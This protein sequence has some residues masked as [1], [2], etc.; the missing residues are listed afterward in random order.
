MDAFFASVEVLD[1]PS[2]QGKPVVVG[3]DANRGVVAAASYEARKFGI[4]SAL[5]MAIAIRRCPH[6]IFLPPRISRYR[7]IS[8]EIF[9]IFQS[10]T[11]LV[12][13]ISL[14]EAFLDVT[15]SFRLFGPAEEIAAAIKKQVTEG[16]GLTVSAGIASSKLVAKIASDFDKPDGLTIVPAG[17]EQ[18]F[19]APLPITRL[20]GAGKATR[21]AL[22]LLG[23]KTIGDLSRLPPDLLQRKFGKHGMSLYQASLGID[24]R[25]VTPG[26][27]M[28][29]I[30]HEETFSADLTDPGQ[31]HRE[32]LALSDKVARRMRRYGVLG[33]CVTLKV[34]YND[35][36][37]ATRSKTIGQPTDDSKEIFRHVIRLLEKTKA[38]TTP[39]RLLGISLSH[40]H[41]ESKF[42]TSLFPDK[43]DRL[44]QMLVNKAVDAIN[45]KFGITAILK[46]RLL[47]DEAYRS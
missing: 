18:S 22:S 5:A 1:N 41:M 4:H 27:E 31:I 14:D 19:L 46:G 20:W 37:L 47:D 11:P 39:V 29:S 8:K 28:K 34:K 9:T 38:G 24:D 16:I 26:R 36:H 15:G 7:E 40:L 25:E 12:E 44:K 10:Y 21:E 30:G 3:G 43:T 13:P 33:R 2:L 23:V 17:Q 45:E 35:F 6:G 32:L 42:Q